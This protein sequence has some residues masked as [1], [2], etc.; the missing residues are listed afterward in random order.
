MCKK[1]KINVFKLLCSCLLLQ[2]KYM[3]KFNKSK[4]EQ[5]EYSFKCLKKEPTRV[6]QH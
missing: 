2:D 6:Q 4:L 3:A 5:T 1:T